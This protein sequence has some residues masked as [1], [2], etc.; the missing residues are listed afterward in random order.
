MTK[1]ET[2]LDSLKDLP[3][4][5]GVHYHFAH[6]AL[7]EAARSD[8]AGFF[9]A[10][11]GAGA[12]EYLL[13]L[14]RNC[15]AQFPSSEDRAESGGLAGSVRELACGLRCAL[16]VMPPPERMTEAHLA[17]AVL[18]PGRRRLGLFKA[19]D[20]VRYFT[21]EITYDDERRELSNLC[22]WQFGPE[23]ERSRLGLG[24]GCPV[25]AEAF[26]AAVSER[27]GG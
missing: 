13:D 23:G 14:W 12:G 11:E 6:V 7:P 19:P 2:V 26:L 20:G 22:E 15:R 17:A 18:V 16:V 10:L 8:P 27:A 21:L 25:E 5:R 4:P 3:R 9:S 1:D 24:T